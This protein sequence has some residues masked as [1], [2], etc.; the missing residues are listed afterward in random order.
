[1]RCLTVFT[2]TRPALPRQAHGPRSPQHELPDVFAPVSGRLTVSTPTAGSQPAA[3]HG[4]RP[5]AN[6]SN[7]HS[8]LPSHAANARSLPPPKR[9]PR[10]HR[11]WFP[12][13]HCMA[14]ALSSKM[15]RFHGTRWRWYRH[16][17]AGHL[18][19]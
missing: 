13:P 9:P 10:P 17:S 7:I 16:A 4:A 3:A 6:A 8:Q 18:I 1:M 2:S 19:A 12:C 11:R 14:V 15:Q 5:P